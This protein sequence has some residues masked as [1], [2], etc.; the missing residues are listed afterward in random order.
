MRKRAWEGVPQIVAITRVSKDGKLGL[1]KAVREQ[2]GLAEGRALYLDVQDE[3]L[4]T[5]ESG[6]GQEL[7]VDGRNRTCLPEDV[8]AELGLGKGALAGLVQRPNAVALKV[9]EIAEAGALQD[10]ILHRGLFGAINVRP[11]S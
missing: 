9:V 1:K 7:P 4:L 5:T 11:G 10:E 6:R 8:R 3:V 2:I